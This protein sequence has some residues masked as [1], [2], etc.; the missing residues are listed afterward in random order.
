M[1]LRLGLGPQGNS[2]NAVPFRMW[3]CLLIEDGFL[4]RSENGLFPQVCNRIEGV[5][6]SVIIFVMHREGTA[7]ADCGKAV[8]LYWGECL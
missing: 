5:F 4:K 1:I 3:I 2:G 8:L 6:N 7:F